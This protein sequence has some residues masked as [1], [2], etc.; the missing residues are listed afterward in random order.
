MLAEL[1]QTLDHVPISGNRQDYDSAIIDDDCLSKQ[2]AATRRLSLQRL[3]ELYGLDPAIP[4]FRV[5]R[6]L[7]AADDSSR[8]LL[9]MLAALARDPLL[10]ATAPV[11]AALPEGAE[12][13]RAAMRAALASAVSD[14]LNEATLG[15]VVRNAASSWSQSG[16]LVGRTFKFR[17]LVKATAPA[18]AFAL[19]LA[20]AAGLATEESFVSGWIRMLDCSKSNARALAA[21]AK[22]M[23]L[24]DL[25]TAGEV[26]ELSLG[27]LDP[28]S[29]TARPMA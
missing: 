18:V 14:R 22:G 1:A 19:Y 8:P 29:G 5:L 12:F 24:I 21:A 20:H 27:R 13:H 26:I 25:R 10:L 17:H 3:R 15:K 23:G 7:W 28:G 9:A 4:L 11:I 2:T 16:H 6:R